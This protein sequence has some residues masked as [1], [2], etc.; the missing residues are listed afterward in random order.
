MSKV[1]NL[2][3]ES[4]CPGNNDRTVFDPQE[5]QALAATILEHGLLQPITVNRLAGD[6]YQIIAGERRWRACQLLNWTHIDSIIMEVTQEKA[7][8]L[9][10]AENVSRADLDPIDEANAYR[11]RIDSGWTVEQCAQAAGVSVIR[12]NF[13]LK[14][15][16]L[17]EDL[18]SLVRSGNLM[19]GYAQILSGSGL[20]MNRQSL[21]VRALQANPKPTPGWFRTIV[22][23]YLTQQNQLDLFDTGSFLVMQDAPVNS[24]PE[25]PPH[26]STTTP[27]I[28]GT[29][30]AIIKNQIN[31]W[32]EAAASW[33]IIGK[34]FKSQECQ[35]AAQALNY[36]L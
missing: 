34:P 15:L 6:D 25:D 13:R 12:V 22:G 20:D 30:K 14:L 16:N 19:L 27:P 24:T 23:E 29:G 8:A 9:M 36:L 21:A 7:S 26:P 5:L 28:L 3:I 1:S 31:F 18:Q 4:I 33:K 35:A 11:K 2:P 32:Y 17:R 10:L